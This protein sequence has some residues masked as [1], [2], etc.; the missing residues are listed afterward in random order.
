TI[1]ATFFTLLV[2]GLVLYF[3]IKYR[4]GNKVDRSRPMYENLKLELT[5]TFIPLVLGLVFFYFGASLFIKMRTPPDD[6]QEVFV[7]GK[8]WMWHIQHS[9]GVREN[10][11]L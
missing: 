5:W 1:L 3:A 10:N 6:A 4:V 8:Q 9:N 11:T 2:M 7:I